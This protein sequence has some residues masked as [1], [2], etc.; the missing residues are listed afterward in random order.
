MKGYPE[1]FKDGFGPR[2]RVIE[3]FDLQRDKK[4]F[5]VPSTLYQ[6]HLWEFT[7][8][9]P[10]GPVRLD[11]PVGHAFWTTIDTARR[12]FKLRVQEF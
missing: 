6:Y 11:N 10:S 7:E 1:I 8:E 3:G 4:V 5:S 2:W 9:V 12:R